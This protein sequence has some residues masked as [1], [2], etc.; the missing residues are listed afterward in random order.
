VGLLAAVT[1]V[2]GA[3]LAW[4]Q[5]PKHRAFTAALAGLSS[6]E[7]S[8]AIRSLS[9]REIP[10][11]PEVLAAAMELAGVVA[12]G[13]NPSRGLWVL[14]LVML[15]LFAV[16]AIALIVNGNVRQGV[17][18]AGLGLVFAGGVAWEWYALAPLADSLRVD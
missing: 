8:Q 15:G 3:L 2:F 17:A 11:D 18:W 14:R 9:G 4:G 5:Q 12:A 13:R 7:R 16:A 10:T 1:L 6:S